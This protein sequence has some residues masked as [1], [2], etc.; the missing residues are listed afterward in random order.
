MVMDKSDSSK[1]KKII[2]DMNLSWQEKKELS[3]P[4]RICYG[5]V[6][7]EG[8]VYY[9]AWYPE[10]E[11]ISCFAQTPRFAFDWLFLE[12]I[13]YIKDKIRLKEEIPE[14]YYDHE[15]IE[16]VGDM[17]KDKAKAMVE[18]DIEKTKERGKKVTVNT[19]K[20]TR[21]LMRA[22]LFVMP[23]LVVM[24]FISI[25]EEEYTLGAIQLL[26]LIGIYLTYLSNKKSIIT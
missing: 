18:H 9:V 22:Q 1:L 8:E 2:N 6:I 7:D 23:I 21:W 13:M 10:L 24:G 3:K 11:N 17:E 12:K 26:A 4:H 15:V 25:W 5:R 20:S 14:A 16:Y 19:H